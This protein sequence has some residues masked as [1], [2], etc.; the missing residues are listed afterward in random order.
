MVLRIFNNKYLII[1]LLYLYL[2][3]ALFRII[4]SHLASCSWPFNKPAIDESSMTMKVNKSCFQVHTSALEKIHMPV[5][6][7]IL[8]N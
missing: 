4:P 2:P 7:L 6:I 3:N 5:T 8:E 1:L